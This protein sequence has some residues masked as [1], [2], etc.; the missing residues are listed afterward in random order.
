MYG[1]EISSS[2]DYLFVSYRSLGIMVY[3]ISDRY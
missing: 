3:D 2:G 1:M